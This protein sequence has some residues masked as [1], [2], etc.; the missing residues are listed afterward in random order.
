MADIAA[1]VTLGWSS[2]TAGQNVITRTEPDRQSATTMEHH[3]S[4]SYGK[5]QRTLFWRKTGHYQTCSWFNLSCIVDTNN[6]IHVF[7]CQKSTR[8]WRRVL[9]PLHII[10]QVHN[11][12]CFKKYFIPLVQNSVNPK[13][14]LISPVHWLDLCIQK[15]IRGNGKINRYASNGSLHLITYVPK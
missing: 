11:N 12:M 13:L 3:L 10:I 5:I 4:H 6:S 9:E 1:M 14:T 2:L 8:K 15:C 7:T